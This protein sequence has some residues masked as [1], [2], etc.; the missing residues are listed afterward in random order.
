MV[1]DERAKHLL[2]TLE[3]AQHLGIWEWTPATN[4]MM[5]SDGLYEILEVSP[6]VPPTIQGLISTLHP[7][8]RP[9][10]ETHLNRAR[11]E[12]GLLAFRCQSRARR[13][14][15]VRMQRTLAD[16]GSLRSIVG[17]N[18]DITD[19]A[20]ATDPAAAVASLTGAIAHEI[21][22]PLAV[23]SA[24]LQM[25]PSSTATADALGAVDRICA[26]I[27]DLNLYAR[28]DLGARSPLHLEQAIAMALAEMRDLETRATIVSRLD[29]TSPVSA[30]G[31]AIRRVVVE[32]IE[33]ALEAVSTTLL[34]EVHVSTRSDGRE[35]SVFEVTDSG[36]GIAPVLQARVFD[37]FYTTK[38]V[39]RR[40][41]GLAICRGILDS[42]GGSITIHSH[43]GGGTRV[44]VAL[45]TTPP[46]PS[47][48]EPLDLHVKG[49][50]A[51]RGRVL[52]VDDEVLFA[53][54]LSRLLSVEHEV[55]IVNNGQLAL[56]EIEGGAR[57]DSILCDVMMP[58]MTGVELHTALLEVAPEQADRMI[59]V[60][61]G[62]RDARAEEL[63]RQVESFEKPCDVAVL[64]D[65]VRRRVAAS[66]SRG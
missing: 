37:P 3:V 34:K 43:E 64:R 53:K 23:I 12:R 50:D 65:A 59:F 27:G 14:L 4:E 24:V 32:L 21:N 40:G 41:L 8:D 47:A 55:T 48:K 56:D 35:W 46:Q 1:A 51:K 49:S 13:I 62:T 18:Q 19:D 54:A 20:L 38:G 10:F 2:G 45:P 44:V 63:L 58:V 61:G 57:F 17:T 29:H 30:N 39:G 16:D 31:A 5:W 52:I 60:T 9:R 6:L 28:G 11:R 33:N 7:A 42:L 66:R 25:M 26:I 36:I 22:N 15:Q